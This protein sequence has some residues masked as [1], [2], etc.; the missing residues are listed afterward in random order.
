MTVGRA[1][2]AV[3]AQILGQVLTGWTLVAHVAGWP[4]VSIWVVA[5]LLAAAIVPFRHDGSF[6]DRAAAN[7]GAALAVAGFLGWDALLGGLGSIGG[8]GFS[9][10][11]EALLML[12]AS[13]LFSLAGGLFWVLSRASEEAR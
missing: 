12:C 11:L 8:G 1:V 7:F 5:F 2:G 9:L 6:R 4:E 3:S 10:G 13:V